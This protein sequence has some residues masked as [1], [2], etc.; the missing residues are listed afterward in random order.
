MWLCVISNKH[1]KKEIASYELEARNAYHAEDLASE[2]FETELR[3]KPRLRAQYADLHA[4]GHCT[5][6]VCYIGD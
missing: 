5:I 3:H 2:M 1:T 6:E 4:K